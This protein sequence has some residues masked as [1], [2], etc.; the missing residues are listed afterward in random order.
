VQINLIS[1]AQAAGASDPGE[2]IGGY[3]SMPGQ[4]SGHVT[5][6]RPDRG[7]QRVVHGGPGG[8]FGLQAVEGRRGAPG[9]GR[10]PGVGG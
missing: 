6:L 4:A 8:Q 1:A 3:A 10:V 5:W 9:A 7:E 2:H